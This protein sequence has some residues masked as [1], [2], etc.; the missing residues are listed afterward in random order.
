MKR[1][2]TNFLALLPP[3]VKCRFPPLL[4]FLL[5][6]VL[7]LFGT[8]DSIERELV[9]TRFRVVT[10]PATGDLVIVMIDPRSISEL[11]TW[12]WPRNFHAEI[13]EI[14]LKAGARRVA[15]DVEFGA[16]STPEADRRFA[17]ALAAAK[18]KVVLP[19]FAQIQSSAD[20]SNLVLSGPLRAFARHVQVA[21]INTRPAE[22][23]MIRRMT[24]RQPWANRTVPTMSV[25]L[26]GREEAPFE[27]FN[28]D[29]G[30]DRHS[31]PRISYVDVLRGRFDPEE[32]AGKQFLIGATAIELGDQ[33]PVPIAKSVPGVF[34]QGL[35]FE[36]LAQDRALQGIGTAPVLALVFFVAALF[37]GIYSAL[38]WRRALALTLAGSI[39]M[40][41]MS[42]G[43]QAVWPVLLD[44]SPVILVLILLFAYS[45]VRR[46]DQQAFRLLLQGSELRRTNAMMKSV[47]DNTF[48]GIVI[49]KQ[50][51]SIRTANAAVARIFGYGED[52]LIDQELSLLIPEITQ[53]N[54]APLESILLVDAGPRELGGQRKDGSSFSLE[55]TVTEMNFDDEQMFVGI[56]RDVTERKIYQDKLEY[57]AVHD[58]LTGLPNRALLNDR[59][60]HDLHLAKRENK[61]LA[62]LPLDLDCFKEVNDT[63]GHHIGDLLLKMVAERLTVPLRDTDTIARFGG[64]EFA[65]LLPAVSDQY[66]AQAVARRIIESLKSPFL[67]DKIELEV[68][69]S[70]GIAMYPEHAETPARLI[71]AADVAMY[72]AKKAGTGLAEYDADKDRSSVRQLTVTGDLRQAIE[73][74]ELAIVFQPKIDLATGRAAGGEVLSRWVHPEHGFI[75]PDEFIELAE[76]TGLIRSLTVWMFNTALRSLS[77]WQRLGLGMAMSV[78]ISARNLHERDL[79]EVIEGLVN[80]WKIDREFLTLEITESAIMIDPE[81][82][83]STIQRLDELGMR[84]SIDDF[85]TGYSSLSYLKRLPVDELKIDKTFVMNMTEDKSDEVIVRSTIDLAHN[86]GLKVVA[87]GVEEAAH[88]KRLKELGCELGQGYYFAR[89]MPIAEF[90]TWLEESPWGYG[91]TDITKRAAA[92]D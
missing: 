45:V 90:T 46:V 6:A 69:V 14:L 16:P 59:L 44:S 5:V 56:V 23:G 39:F 24:V 54:D 83:M 7:Y 8:F 26:A 70:V 13:V 15:F 52:E 89:P 28:I 35:A 80:E 36:S 72:M 47:V 1:R 82:A 38:S 62:I 79:P 60:E 4:I 84:L 42:T 11:R 85:G 78:N 81:Q 21:S 43:V 19:V 3:G 86:L 73:G 55:L 66:Q 88:A 58:A 41:L 49:I 9:D 22:D 75:S 40:L 37:G 92:G 17:Q 65:I 34:V 18:E 87:E 30:I 2:L 67:L 48:D 57:Q 27:M 68:G 61:P 74:N 71:Q 64:D 51:G 76:Q 10:R 50:K 25:R 53:D 31:I 32:I 91:A 20:G 12:P 29:Y 33:M 63:L 77:E